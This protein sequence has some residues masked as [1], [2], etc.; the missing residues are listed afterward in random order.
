[1]SECDDTAVLFGVRVSNITF[2]GVCTAVDQRIAER[3][4][5]F[6]ATPNVNMICSYQRNP[7]FAE[8]YDQAFLW[9]PDGQP[10]LWVARLLGLKLSE[11]LSGS[12]MVPLITAHAAKRGHRVFFFG[13]LAGAAEISAQRM[14]QRYP[15]LQIAG[16]YVP[17]YGFEHDPEENAK[18][19]A[20][21]RDSQADIC[22]VALG[23]PKQELWM[24]RHREEL[25]V[26]VCMGVG[27]ALDFLSGKV[28]R[29]PRWVQQLG[30]E[31]LWRLLQEPRRLWRRYLVEDIVIVPMTLR[32]FFRQ[33]L[34]RHAE[35]SG[36][37]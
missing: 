21:V 30:F 33:R 3:K 10:L 35:D 23:C 32:E 26:P 19:I 5:G 13:G 6:I 36:R 20:A 16:V 12:D 34:G 8:A 27:A 14:R 2:D 24:S 31:W 1:M 22:W 28:K 18:A 4:P 37:V 9:L 15:D 29:A 7:A 17:P 11:K 25:G